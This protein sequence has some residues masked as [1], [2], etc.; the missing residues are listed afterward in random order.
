MIINVLSA[1]GGGI[2]NRLSPQKNDHGLL[3]RNMSDEVNRSL[4]T[5]S[6]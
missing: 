5:F 4:S 3:L 2:D 1:V 6:C